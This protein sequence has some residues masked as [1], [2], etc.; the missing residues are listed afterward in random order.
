[1]RLLLFL[2]LSIAGLASFAQQKQFEQYIGWSG[3][4]VSLQTFQNKTT[5]CIVVLRADS[6]KV[7]LMEGDGQYE[8]IFTVERS[9]GENYLGGF[10]K[11]GGV[12]LFMDNGSNP[13]IRCWVY[14]RTERKVTATQIPFAIK[15]SKLINRLSSDNY[16]F[17]FTYNKKSSEFVIYKFSSANQCD[18]IR[19]ADNSGLWE[20]VTNDKIFFRELNIERADME[21]ECKIETAEPRNKIYVRNDTLLLIVNNVA[22]YTDVYSFDIARGNTDQRR[23]THVSA[24]DYPTPVA[25]NSFLLKDKLYFC[26]AS[27]E[28]LNLQVLNFYTGKMLNEFYANRDAEISF[29]N[30]NIAA[31]GMKLTNDAVIPKGKTKKL[32]GQMAKGNV[33]IVAQPLDKDTL[34]A[35][36]IASFREI[37]QAGSWSM[38][39]GG[40]MGMYSGG[41][42]W[43]QT[44]RFKTILNS[45]SY[46]HMPGIIPPLINER[47][48]DYIKDTRVSDDGQKLYALHGSYYFLFYDKKQRT[49]NAVKFDQ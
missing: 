24:H 10:I 37:Q 4:F 36:T 25:F 31:E 14:N 18:T 27:K 46:E 16:F 28:A 13:G 15:N 47:M 20:A 40:S 12:C 35:I 8:E 43:T 30:T 22:G 45:N 11:N 6:V 2:F 9:L 32:L 48:D 3:H 19:Y 7:F 29:I 42:T 1:M 5:A 44:S 49:L 38:G 41:S 23:I 39:P 26:S 21:G 17:Y 34:V 33:V